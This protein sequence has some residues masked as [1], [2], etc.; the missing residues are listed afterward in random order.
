MGG[1]SAPIPVMIFHPFCLSSNYK[2]DLKSLEGDIHGCGKSI[3]KE[4][5][6]NEQ[7]VSHLNRSQNDANVTRKMIAQSLQ[8]QEALQVQTGT[9]T[10]VLHE[11][12]EALHRTKMVRRVHGR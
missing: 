10:R 12:E 9:Y 6:K 8:E 7:L 2:R 1:C 4:E 3:R 11:T 5:E